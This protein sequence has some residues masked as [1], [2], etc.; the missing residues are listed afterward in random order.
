MLILSLLLSGCL[1]GRTKLINMGSEEDLEMNIENGVVG[2]EVTPT[3]EIVVSDLMT[4]ERT[5]KSYSEE[6]LVR[7][8]VVY[9]IKENNKTL[10][11][12][13]RK[14]L[15]GDP[16]RLKINKTVILFGVLV[17]DVKKNYYILKV[18]DTIER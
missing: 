6:S 8:S 13:P 11:A 10:V 12:V 9:K 17:Q 3:D 1:T 2:M 16:I 18:R 7:L 14:D 4:Y 5:S 15:I